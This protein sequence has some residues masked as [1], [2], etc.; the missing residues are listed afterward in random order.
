MSELR[1][2]ETR[3]SLHSIRSQAS[4]Y[5]QNIDHQDVPEHVEEDEEPDLSLANI[6]QYAIT[7]ISTLMEIKYVNLK[8]LNPINDLKD[9]SANNWNYFF[10]GFFAWLS[11][12]F[13]FFCTS[14]SGSQIADSLNVTTAD[15]TW[16]LSAVLMVRSS[17]AIIFGFWTDNYSRKWPFI[18]CAAMF[19]AL[20][21]GTGFVKTYEQFL[22]VR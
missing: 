18:T 11:A 12:S 20:Q 16:G 21:I 2:H 9:M 17:G 10:M 6:A 22:A 14:V 7:R 19:M 4:S 1:R 5:F 8:D 3:N 15:I 13:D